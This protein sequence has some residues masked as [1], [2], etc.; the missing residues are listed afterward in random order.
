MIP[1]KKKNPLSLKLHL[2]PTCSKNSLPKRII[3]PKKMTV[4]LPLKKMIL[5]PPHLFIISLLSFKTLKLYLLNL[6]NHQII[7]SPSCLVP[8]PKESLLTA[9]REQLPPLKFIIQK[10]LIYTPNQLILNLIFLEILRASPQ[11]LQ[12]RRVFLLVARRDHP[13]TRKHK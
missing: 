8:P 3:R 13:V 9:P 6:L 2:R 12:I 4:H 11:Q 7:N 10:P 5:N 1:A